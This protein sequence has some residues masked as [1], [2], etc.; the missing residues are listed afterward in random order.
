MR[1]AL[2]Y[3]LRSGKTLSKAEQCLSQDRKAASIGKG[4]QD[5]L[6]I[7]GVVNWYGPGITHFV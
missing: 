2:R 3:R 1:R 5:L 4:E 6:Y 7:A